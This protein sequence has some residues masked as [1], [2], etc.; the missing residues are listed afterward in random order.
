MPL[1]GL[2]M[3]PQLLNGAAAALLGPRI[4]AVCQD[5]PSGRSVHYVAARGKVARPARVGA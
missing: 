1:T 4:V 3:M 5:V 2:G